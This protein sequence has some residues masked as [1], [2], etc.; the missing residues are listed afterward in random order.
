MEN[1]FDMDDSN[2]EINA[3]SDMNI[4]IKKVVNVPEGSAE[5]AV[6]D[7]MEVRTVV[8]TVIKIFLKKML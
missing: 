4:K 8:P 3:S 1:L 6:V 7:V 5:N 2:A